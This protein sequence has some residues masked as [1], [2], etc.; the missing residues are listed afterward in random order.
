MFPGILEV[1]YAPLSAN[2]LSLTLGSAS[3]KP[4]SLPCRR[5]HK[6]LD[7]RSRTDGFRVVPPVGFVGSAVGNT[8]KT[9]NSF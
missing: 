7:L 8:E 6:G 3:D 9:L 1:L 2:L 4:N 5:R